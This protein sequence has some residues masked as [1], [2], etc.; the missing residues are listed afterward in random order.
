M[1]FIS[2]LDNLFRINPKT[3]NHA[4]GYSTVASGNTAT[5]I[6]ESVKQIVWKPLF[7]RNPESFCRGILR[8]LKSTE[9]IGLS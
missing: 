9:A 8:L 1:V 4:T 7:M 5:A 6:G 3:T 2:R